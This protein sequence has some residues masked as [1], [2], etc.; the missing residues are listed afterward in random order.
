MNVDRLA[1]LVLFATTV[2]GGCTPEP[3]VPPAAEIDRRPATI[4]EPPVADASQP[5]GRFWV[6][7]DGLAAFD[8]DGQRVAERSQGG[9][10]ARRLADGRIVMLESETSGRMTLRVLDAAFNVTREV[11]VP[12]GFDPEACAIAPAGQPGESEWMLETHSARDFAI[13]ANPARVCL[14]LRDGVDS[15]AF[16]GVGVAVDLATG[17]TQA[18]IVH[19]EMDACMAVDPQPTGLPEGICDSAVV[20]EL[21]VELESAPAPTTD[22]WP[23][24][25]DPESH[26]LSHIDE[27]QVRLCEPGSETDWQM[28][29]MSEGNSPSG[30]WMALSGR[31]EQGDLIHRDL[32]LLDRQTGVLLQVREDGEHPRHFVEVTAEQIFGDEPLGVVAMVG[33]SEVEWLP[34]DRLWVDGRLLIPERRAIVEIGGQLAR[35]L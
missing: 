19:A 30:R 15:M 10:E 1:P 3:V 4:V 6:V 35:T 17:G 20:G 31:W 2:V 14:T 26:W 25:Y 8:L 27:Q 12:T 22:A 13:D 33:A 7:N 16:V 29:A 18:A 21:W 5:R 34:G 28:C 32:V 9:D 24:T 11:R 23:F